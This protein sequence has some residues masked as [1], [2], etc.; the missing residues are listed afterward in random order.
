[1]HENLFIQDLTKEYTVK[2][3]HEGHHEELIAGIM[4]QLGP[5]FESSEQ[6]IYV[7]LDDIHKAC[8]K[9][10]AKMLGYNSADEW[11]NEEVSFTEMFVDK[12]S[13]EALVS[14]YSDAM[15]HMIGSSINVTWKNKSGKS[16][17]TQVIMVPI[18]FQ[19]HLFALH[20]VSEI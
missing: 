17:K 8:N 7:Y 10:F 18:S 2:A 5:V 12:K 1:M 20:F 11:A 15:D 6:G 19:N 4:K 13:Q 14:A 3:E 9:K 16:V